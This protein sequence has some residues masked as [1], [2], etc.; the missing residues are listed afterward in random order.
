MDGQ[1]LFNSLRNHLNFPRKKNLL[2]RQ[3]ECPGGRT[4]S[5]TKILCYHKS[6]QPMYYATH[7]H[8]IHNYSY[9]QNM[10][11]SRKVHR[12]GYYHCISVYLS[13]VYPDAPLS[14]QKIFFAREIEMVTERSITLVYYL[15]MLFLHTD[16]ILQYFTN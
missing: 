2:I 8:A 15:L 5:Y 12:L 13:S 6:L 11:G 7:S 9:R 1:I 14:D 16:I 3:T 4:D 10:S